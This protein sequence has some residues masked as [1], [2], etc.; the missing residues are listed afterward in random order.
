M[1]LRTT[2]AQP[3][4]MVAASVGGYV[5]LEK[6]GDTRNTS[7]AAYWRTRISGHLQVNGIQGG[8]Q[9]HHGIHLCLQLQQVPRRSLAP[10]WHLGNCL[11]RIVHPCALAHRLA[12]DPKASR[13]QHLA[14]FIPASMGIIS[15]T[16]L[17]RSRQCGEQ[18]WLPGLAMIVAKHDEVAIK[19]H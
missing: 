19:T 12:H 5:A 18:L 7:M 16:P 1:T 8:P 10:F 15:F 11:A 13:A 17:H 14:Q 4:C 3:Y 9:L 2:T 6:R